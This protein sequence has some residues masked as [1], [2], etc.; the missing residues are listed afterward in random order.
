MGFY[1]WGDKQTPVLR[2]MKRYKRNSEKRSLNRN[3]LAF[4]TLVWLIGW[5]WYITPSYGSSAFGAV[6]MLVAMGFAYHDMRRFFHKDPVDEQINDMEQQFWDLEFGR[7]TGP[8]KEK[9]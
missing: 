7:N 3:K 8:K 6:V 4:L 2:K 5:L 9:E 1:P